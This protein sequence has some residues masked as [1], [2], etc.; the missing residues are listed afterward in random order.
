LYLYTAFMGVEG[1]V[2]LT[3]ALSSF[4]FVW[5]TRPMNPLC[6]TN[7]YKRHRF[8]AEVFSHC[9][10]LYFRFCPCCRDGEEPMAERGVMLTYEAV[11]DRCR[12]FGQTYAKKVRRW[13]PSPG[14]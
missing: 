8:P 12:K 2:K 11:P 5:H 3:F 6:T 1:I 7:I 14:D 9:V 4:G 13:H 10:W